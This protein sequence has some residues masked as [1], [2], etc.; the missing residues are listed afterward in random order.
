MS[1]PPVLRRLS[2]LLTVPLA[3]LALASEARAQCALDAV[4][5]GP[6]PDGTPAAGCCDS[7][8]VAAWCENGRFCRLDCRVA[9]GTLAPYCG[10]EFPN[11]P[12]LCIESQANLTS[13]DMCGGGSSGGNCDC[14]SRQCG[15]DGCGNSCGVCGPNQTCDASGQCS[16][17]GGG[18]GGPCSPSCNGRACGDDGCGGS[19]GNCGPNQACS[20]AGQCSGGGTGC[21]AQCS[22][23]VCGDDGCGGSC[24]SC[25][26]GQTCENGSCVGGG[27]G[28]ACTPECERRVCGDDGCGGSCGTCADGQSCNAG[29]FCEFGSSTADPAPA[30]DASVPPQECPAGQYWNEFAAACVVLGETAPSGAGDEGGCGGGAAGGLFGLGAGLLALTRRRLSLR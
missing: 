5:V 27:G 10:R 13:S 29:G 12:P 26:N 20:A 3:L 28:G 22:G 4:D 2:L 6:C 7:P 9:Y 25:D 18:T 15:D 1:L 14:G 21:T 8:S 16:S 23:K 17:S 30:A 19:C 24:G 11:A